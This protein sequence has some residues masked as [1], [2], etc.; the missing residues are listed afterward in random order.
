MIPNTINEW[1]IAHIEQL[2]VQ[3][4][5]EN[6]RFDF[7]EMLPHK[8]SASDKLRLVK[9]CASFQIRP[10]GAF[11]SSGYATI[12]PQP[13]TSVL[14]GWIR[15]STS[16]LLSETT[17]RRSSRPFRG[18]SGIRCNSRRVASSMWFTSRL[19]DGNRTRVRRGSLVVLQAHVE[20][21][22]GNVVQ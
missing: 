16:P 22:R 7:K 20:R 13:Q 4:M 8:A 21:Y 14:S 15:R 5:F 9:A 1:N 11:S 17:R 10:P 2:L 12:A 3:G 19:V 18:R 6:D